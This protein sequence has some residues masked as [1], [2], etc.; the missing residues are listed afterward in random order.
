MIDEL[1]RA[2]AAREQK[3]SLREG[4]FELCKKQ[5]EEGW[6]DEEKRYSQSLATFNS[7][8]ALELK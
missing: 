3:L 8:N 6:K 5:R 7:F 1:R 4:F 2:H